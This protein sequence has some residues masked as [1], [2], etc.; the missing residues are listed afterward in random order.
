MLSWNAERVLAHQR[1]RGRDRYD[2]CER[3]NIHGAL[4]MDWVERDE[5]RLS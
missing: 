4:T 1:G 2:C 3:G 5:M